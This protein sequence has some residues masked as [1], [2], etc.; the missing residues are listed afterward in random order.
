MNAVKNPVRASASL[1]RQEKPG[2]GIKKIGSSAR[3]RRHQCGAGK[4]ISGL[5]LTES[6]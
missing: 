2:P 1:K 6:P 5:A 3:F 4:S